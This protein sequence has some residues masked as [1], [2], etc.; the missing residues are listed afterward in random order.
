MLTLASWKSQVPCQIVTIEE[1]FGAVVK[2]DVRPDLR[3]QAL[4]LN[5]G[6]LTQDVK[7][8]VEARMGRLVGAADLEVP[9]HPINHALL[10]VCS[11]WWSLM[12]WDLCCCET[13]LSEAEAKTVSALAL[14]S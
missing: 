2:K 3:Y 5:R 9:Y 14:P 8:L 11:L 12:R 7:I 6:K 13:S 10:Q 4:L 1:L